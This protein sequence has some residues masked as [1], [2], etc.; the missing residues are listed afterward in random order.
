M[1]TQIQVSY[2]VSGNDVGAYKCIQMVRA[3]QQFSQILSN[4]QCNVNVKR[5]FSATLHRC[6]SD[7]PTGYRHRNDCVD[8][9]SF[10]RAWLFRP[11]PLLTTICTLPAATWIQSNSRSSFDDRTSL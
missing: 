9:G 7:R 2:A 10:W 1:V 4:Q 11:R 3:A 6:C 5:C 8:G